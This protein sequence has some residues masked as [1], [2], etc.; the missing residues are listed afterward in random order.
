MAEQIQ[1]REAQDQENQGTSRERTKNAGDARS[2]NDRSNED[3]SNEQK[4]ESKQASDKDEKSEKKDERG[5]FEKHPKA[6]PALIVFVILLLV[7]G[8]IW[9][10]HHRQWES[11]DDAQVDGNIYSISA[12]IQGHVV[13]VTV[14]DGDHVQAGQVLA[15]IDPADYQ[16]A[17]DRA[18]AEYENAQAALLSAELNVPVSS[19]GS[20]SQISSAEADVLNTQAGVSAAQEQ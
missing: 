6:K 11:T 13:R 2:P 1:E 10:W 18:Q 4:P 19:V 16:V 5:F 14:N 8:G 17:L 20:R 9:Y 15:E 7:G 12:R 3:R